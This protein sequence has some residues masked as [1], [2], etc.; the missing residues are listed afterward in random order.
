M[1]W[2]AMKKAMKQEFVWLQAALAAAGIAL[3]ARADDA[4]G[5][6]RLSVPSNDAAVVEMPFAPF[7]AASPTNFLSGPFT[8]DGG[9][10]SDVVYI[11][12]QGGSAPTNAYFS[13]SDGAWL[14]P[15]TGGPTAATAARGDGLVV[16]SGVASFP[17]VFDFFLFGRCTELAS[18]SGLPRFG[19]MEVDPLGVFVDLGVQ[20]ADNV[21][22][23]L[24]AHD[25]G[26]A[27]WLH[28]G[29]F[30][31]GGFAWRGPAPVAT[32]LYLVSDASRDTDG[33]GLPDALETYVYGTSPLLADTDG[34]GVDDGLEVAWGT[35]PLATPSG[36]PFSFFEGFERPAVVP[37][38]VSGQNGWIAT[39]GSAT[40]QTNAVHGGMAALDVD[41]CAGGEVSRAVDAPSGVLWL[42]FRVMTADCLPDAIP[43]D[44]AVGVAFDVEGHPVL[45]D[46][47]AVVT[48]RTVAVSFDEEW[49]RC[50]LCIDYPGRVWG[51]YLDGVLVADELSMRGDAPA[52][53]E[54][55][56]S[57]GAG[58]VDDVSL[59]TTRPVGLSSD[60]DPM[61]DE[62]EVAH[63]GSLSRDGS[64]DFDG[65]GLSDADEFA[66]G[67]D[68]AFA[69]TDGDGMPDAWEVAH[70]LAPLDPFDAS[71]DPDGDGI[72]NA[73][74]CA[75]GGDPH[76]REPDPTL[77]QPGLHA[78]FFRTA[79]NFQTIPD[80]SALMP[81]ASAVTTTVD[82]PSEPWPARCPAPG[83]RFACRISGFLRVPE[84]GVYT[85]HLT[86]DDGAALSVNG[87]EVVSDAVPHSSRTASS[88]LTLPAG[89]LPIRI[90]HYENTG[91]EVLRLEWSGPGVA[92]SVVP[93]SALCHVPVDEAP[94]GF[95]RGASAEFYSFASALSAMPDFAGLAPVDVRVVSRI[96]QPSTGGAWAD[97]PASLL[98]RFGAVYSGHLMVPKSGAWNIALE[99]DDGSRLWIDGRL[100]IDHGGLHSMSSKGVCLDLSDGMHEFRVEYF[101]NSGGAGLRLLWALDGFPS[102]AVPERFLFRSAGP[103]D[104]D[105]DGMPDWWESAHGLDA[106][107]PSDAALD[108][109][110]DG[111]ANLAEFGAGTDP[112]SADTDRD[113]LPDAWE[114]AHGTRPFVAD[115]LDDPDGDGLLNVEEMRHGTEPLVADTDGDGCSDYLEVRNSR[116]DPLVSDIAWNAP[117]DV[118]QRTSGAA[119]ASSTGTWRSDEG[120]TAFAAE[121]AGSLTWRLSVPAAG[122]DALAVGVSQHNAFASSATFDLSLYVDGLFVSRQVVSAP[123]GTFSDAFFF[124]P[125]IPAGEHDFRL[126]WHN[127]EVNTFLAVRDLRFVKFAGPD[128]DGDGVPD[129]RNHRAAESSA[130]DALPLESLV[131]PLCVEGRDLWRDVLEI[132]VGYP[133][134]NAAF[135][136]VKTVG[137]GFYADIPLPADGVASVS[138]RDRSLSGS[139]PVSWRD[140][141][142]FAGEFAT[143]ALVVRV[144]DALKIA[145]H[146][147][148]ESEVSVR[149]ADG[150]GWT[151]VTNWTEEVATPYAFESAGLYLVTVTRRGILSD[152]EAHAL[153]EVVSSRFPKRNP[154]ILLDARETLDCPALSPRNLLEHDSELA[155]DAEVS[156][157][158]GV[159]LSMLTHADR[160]LGLVSRLDDGGAISDAVQ[161]TP[162]WADNGT[163]YRVARTYADGSQLVE[164]SLL[165]G[166]VPEG[167]SVTLSIFVSGVTFE[168]GTRTRTLTA[169]DFDED[170]HVTVRFIR[171]RGVTTSVCHRTY[172]YQNGKLI[173]TNE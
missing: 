1:E 171:A 63:F 12:P 118:G 125:E 67:T 165:L 95:A 154:A 28:M 87:L 152:D 21:P 23:D 14:D 90:D 129:W 26:D 57:G 92:R 162:V 122:A 18:P 8:G 139:F 27:P 40:V 10:Q 105:G 168:D 83:D 106:S 2:N 4:A 136:V 157:S 167:T 150:G 70:G 9:P 29:R 11:V 7:A 148:G 17:P 53:S 145:P 81:S 149:I 137:D 64:G 38:P 123:Y 121:R 112:R 15:A 25:G 45:V 143:N 72:A 50:T 51:F 111:L 126:V 142:V 97:A 91:S 44:A 156:A 146:G 16:A 84:P 37:G 173:Y 5:V 86:S 94:P 128:A 52:P 147:G 166:A 59:S 74:E 116:G 35:D 169:D 101:E 113:G 34:D 54:F 39:S 69:D 89:W 124:L 160:D 104:S 85:F 132:E 99:S 62:W 115:A 102:E 3:S 58:L 103:L 140:F 110:G 68:P 119:F 155:L 120:G 49:T 46:G 144:G 36:V 109:D 61:P 163:Y 100:A 153:V 159:T 78:E 43:S 13:A 88:A 134:T 131:S 170:G 133:G 77:R 32:N 19:G 79:A 138:M 22:T 33:D 55:G 151:A 98:D 141:D 164:V 60:G 158:G 114:A 107:D 24:F 82:F 20:A 96:D 66:A 65:D 47:A 71:A 41:A 135:A 130:L 75:K 48:N 73:E 6:M 93:A 76:F 42:D 117:V 30:P 127:W 31:A 80:F 161:V 172:I 56:V 108:P